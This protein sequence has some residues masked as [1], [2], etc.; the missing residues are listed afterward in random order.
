M[1]DKPKRAGK[2][3]VRAD[4][5]WVDPWPSGSWPAKDAEW[6]AELGRPVKR[7]RGATAPGWGYIAAP[8]GKGKKHGT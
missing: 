5:G 6:P 4:Q 3:P 7:K 8:P 2:P 1:K